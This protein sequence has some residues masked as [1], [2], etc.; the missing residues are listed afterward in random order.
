MKWPSCL[1]II[2]HGP[3]AYNELRSKKNE[4]PEYLEFKEEFKRD[5]QS[6][7]CRELAEIVR[8]RYA[9]GVGDYDMP[10]SEEGWVPCR[11]LGGRLH[12][13]APPPDVIF[14]SPYVRTRETYQGMREGGFDPGAAK[15]VHGEE[16]IREQEHGLSLL[17]SD[18]RVFQTIYPEQKKLFDL[19]GSYWYQYPQGESVAQVRDRIRSF[20]NTLVR[21]HAGQVVY[22]ISHHLTK[23]SIRANLERLTPE[24]FQHLDDHETPINCGV[25]IY[26]GDPALGSDGKLVLT[27]YNL[28]LH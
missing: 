10:L 17:F 2:R 8:R 12:T 25:T 18:R 24:Q 3:S 16:R 15:I 13:V 23:L 6:A 11:A 7:R 19:L 9:L 14:I 21:E 4:D 27:H 5:Y 28:K 26:R 1:V 20:T 22:L